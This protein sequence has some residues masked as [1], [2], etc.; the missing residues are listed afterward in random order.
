MAPRTVTPK[1][2]PPRRLPQVRAKS[3]PVHDPE[4]LTTHSRAVYEAARQIHQRIASPGLLGEAPRLWEWVYAA[5]L[6]HDAGKVAEGFQQQ[7]APGAAAWGQRHEVLS[8]AYVDLLAPAAGW[9]TEDRLMIA[10]LVATHHRALFPGGG[11]KLALSQQYNHAT[12]WAEAFTRRRYLGTEQIQ[13]TGAV[14]RE[15][16]AWLAGALGIDPP[17]REPGDLTLAERAR[18]T[19]KELLDLWSGPVEADAGLRS[20]L[21]QGALTLADHAGSA[22]YQLHQHMPLPEDYFARLHE[23]HTPY[24]HQQ[25]AAATDGHMI[26]IAPTGSGK[27]EAGLAWAARQIAGMPGRPRLV[28]TLPYRASLNAARDRMRETL[29]PGSEEEQPDIGLLHGSLAHTLLTEALDDECPFGETK[30]PTAAMARQARARAAAMRLF[31]QRLRVATPHQLLRGAIAGPSHSSV[32]LEQANSVF[33]MDE[34]HAYDPETFGRLCAAMSLWERLGSRF[35]VLSATLAPCMVE[36]IREHRS[37]PVTVHHA[38]PGTSPDRHRLVLDETPLTDPRSI[39]QLAAWLDE[40]YSVLAVTNTVTRARHLFAELADTA[41]RAC[42]D[43]PDAAL[44]LHSRFRNRDRAKIERRLLARHP[45]RTSR[46]GTE[47]RGGLVVAT[48]TVEVS[49]QLD[50]DRGATEAAPIEAVAQRAGRVNRRGLHPE[51]PVPF[52]VHHPDSHHPYDKEALAASWHALTSLVL[53][54][55]DTLSEQDIDTLL[56]LTYD[57]PWGAEWSRRARR[58]RDEFTDTFLTFTE[59]FHDRAEFAD[60]LNKEFDGVEA[61][62]ETDLPVFESH[63]KSKDSDP[64]LAAGLFIPMPYSTFAAH[65]KTGNAYFDRRLKVHVVT[66]DYHPD[67]GLADPAAANNTATPGETIL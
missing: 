17:A 19:F 32:L 58:A 16:I 37:H 45:E 11:G 29:H 60:R 38:P 52:H 51:G 57:T 31:L 43:D 35:A 64:L 59:P 20:V 53:S 49:L 24:P 55:I 13:V 63:L 36:L 3:R 2:K 15:L 21:A 9:S 33:V 66:T 47:R 7:L 56:A 28:W 40:G 65:H 5:A 10:T 4:R 27:T 50:F 22:H 39:D 48:Q 61:I 67:T 42:P 54:G 18:L 44:L 26:L 25:A 1:A 14:H 8:L 34:L 30:M 46:N 12:D 6:L 23:E 62:W 41:R